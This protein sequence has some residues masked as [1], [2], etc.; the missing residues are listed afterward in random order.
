MQVADTVD[1]QGRQRKIDEITRASEQIPLYKNVLP[2]LA[3]FHWVLMPSLCVC[4]FC[5]LW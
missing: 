5:L 1:P 3:M 2:A 4:I